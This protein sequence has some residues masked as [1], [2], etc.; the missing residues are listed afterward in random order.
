MNSIVSYVKGKKNVLLFIHPGIGESKKLIEKFREVNPEAKISIISHVFIPDKDL[1]GLQLHK[2]FILDRRKVSGMSSLIRM[3]LSILSDIRRSKFDLFIM[4][5]RGHTLSFLFEMFTLM[6]G[7]PSIMWDD[8][9]HSIIRMHWGRPFYRLPEVI[10][11]NVFFHFVLLVIY[12][13]ALMDMFRTPPPS[14][15]NFRNKSMLFLR[16]DIELAYEQVTVGGS[17]SHVKG[18]VNAF[19]ELGYDITAIGTGHIDGIAANKSFVASPWIIRD[20]PRELVELLSSIAV[21]TKAKSFLKGTK[22]D[23]IYQRYS[24]YNFA[25]IFLAK[26]FGIPCILEANNSEVEMRQQFSRM[27]YPRFGKRMEKWILTKADLIVCVAEITKKTF[28]AMGLDGTRI[29][30]VPNGANPNVFFPRPKSDALVK[31]HHLQDKIVVGFI[32][33]FYPWHGLEYMCKCIPGAVSQQKN[34]HFLFVGDGD[35][36]PKM[37]DI[38]DKNGMQN[39]VTFTGFVPHSEINDYLSLMDI[40]VSPHAPWKEF[41]GS[42]IKLFEYMSSGKPVVASAV[43]QIA[44]IIRDRENGLL[45]TPGDIDELVAGVVELSNNEMLRAKLGENARQSVIDHYSWTAH[46]EKIAGF[47]REEN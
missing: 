34:L 14:K 33:C 9:T 18:I 26:K 35:E 30:S 25:G 2:T 3:G 39:H 27:T 28:Q 7:A 22:L 42:P 36:K 15:T 1:E 32:G 17:V 13:Y 10:F 5:Y 21:Y 43:G 12:L 20:I 41:F 46:A 23:F 24:M 29:Q 45:V 6:T 38:I 40:V 4:W 8:R 19:N 37:Q 11:K 16:T 44:E 31:K 47:I